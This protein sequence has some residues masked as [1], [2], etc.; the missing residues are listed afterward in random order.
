[1][2]KKIQND[3]KPIDSEKNLIEKIK[4][5]TVM[6]EV[7]SQTPNTTII[8]MEKY[9]RS[10]L[11]ASLDPLVTI[12]WDGKIKDVNAAAE[13]ATGLLRNKLIG[14]DFAE[15]FTDP[16]KARTGYQQ[17]FQDGK[18]FDYELVLKN[19]AGYST[20]V[21]YN[22]SVYKDDEGKIMGVFAAARDITN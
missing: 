18:V 14:T 16:S 21:L 19:I 4:A 11:E 9:S 12:G 5:S 15:Y 10:L 8:E 6:V 20:P 7:Q 2:G 17:A 22:A 3:H 13:N 1:M